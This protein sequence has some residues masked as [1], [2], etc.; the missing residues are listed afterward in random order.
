MLTINSCV[1]QGIEFSMVVMRLL[2]LVIVLEYLA[3]TSI[4]FFFIWLDQLCTA[5]T[6]HPICDTKA[7]LE[8]EL[9][10]AA[11]KSCAQEDKRWCFQCLS[12]QALKTPVT[13]FSGAGAGAGMGTSR[14]GSLEEV[15][16]ASQD[17]SIKDLISAEGQNGKHVFKFKLTKS[18]AYFQTDLW[19]TWRLP[20]LG[21]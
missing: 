6:F 5:K 12:H 4:C 18:K 13:V 21:I 10:D 3:T 14:S 17:S 11:G 15:E 8:K 7:H 9:L 1:Y 19:N 2:H 16:A 20:P